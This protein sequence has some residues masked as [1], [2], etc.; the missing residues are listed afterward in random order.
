MSIFNP[1]FYPTPTEVLDNILFNVDLRNKIVL[2]P[3]C[4]S[5]NII[6]YLKTCGV[7]DIL[8]CETSPELAQISSSKANLIAND[9]LS[10]TAEQ[11][12]HIDMIIANPPFSADE[13]HILHMWNIAPEGCEIISLCNYNT[14]SNKYS[15]NRKELERIIEENGSSES[16]GNCFSDSERKTDV[17]I[18]L[19]R[20]F[21]PRVSKETE[22][23]GYFD[24][25]EEYESQDNGIVRYDELRDTV[26]RYVGAVKM[27]DSV[28]SISKEISSLISP[29]NNGG[30]IQFGAF[31][32][33]RYGSSSKSIDRDTF[34]KQL[35]KQAWK[36]I[37][38]KFD[39]RKYVTE[40]VMSDINK[41]VEKQEHIP[42][43]LK[44][45]YKMI[46]MIVGTHESRMQRVIVEAFERICNFSWKTNNEA[47]EGWKTNSNYKINQNFIHPYL[48]ERDYS[49][50]MRACY[51]RADQLD[52][53]IKA[54]CYITGKDYN[55]Q[56][57]FYNFLSY[58]KVYDSDG[59]AMKDKNGYNDLHTVFEWGKWHKWNDF[60]EIK[61]YKKGTVHFKFIDLEVWQRF[62]T[63]YAR[64][65]GWRLPDFTN[66][67][68][69]GKERTKK[70]GI[71]VYG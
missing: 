61:G 37:F 45:I 56:V 12:S 20:L 42:F 10:V 66:T 54:L 60:F 55:K 65:K 16:L 44:N 39:M 35:Q 33:E 7:K 40:S 17:E 57:S 26:N 6:D 11:I 19:V 27:F 34:K 4:G 1:N 47:G 22:F 41:F 49:G 15:Y 8:C 62:N 23:D 64:I 13:K 32:T 9:F 70:E 38:D 52:D 3:S 58:T 29:I 21:K 30:R 31:F 59:K 71:E 25:S 63:E 43:T 46:E 68:T 24:L 51:S 14:I 28:E 50:N 2:E 5:G 48:V 69:T 67:K 18:G 36:T 53:V